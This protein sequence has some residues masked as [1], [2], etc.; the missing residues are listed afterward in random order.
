MVVHARQPSLEHLSPQRRSTTAAAL[1]R[2]HIKISE[3]VPLENSGPSPVWKPGSIH[4]QS[5][6]PAGQHENHPLPTDSVTGFQGSL[7]TPTSMAMAG[8]D[9][10]A[11]T[12]DFATN[13]PLHESSLPMSPDSNA[14]NTSSGG[15]QSA[16]IVA[17][18]GNAMH[19]NR[20]SVFMRDTKDGVA[21]LPE[22]DSAGFPS[23]TRPSTS[24]DSWDL[25]MDTPN[26]KKRRS[27]SIR[28]AFRRMFSKK[29]KQAP[30]RESP[31]RANGPRHEYHS[32]EP[33]LFPSSRGLDRVTEEDRMTPQK[34]F[35]GR[36]AD[37]DEY[38]NRTPIQTPRL[39]FPMNING[40]QPVPYTENTP[41]IE[42]D[43]SRTYTSFDTSPQAHRRRA[44][45]PSIVIS[46]S[47]AAAL[48]K[49]WNKADHVSGTPPDSADPDRTPTPLIGL[50]ITSNAP[51]KASSKS[52]RR[53]SR[54]ADALRDLAQT[55]QGTTDLRRRSA[56]IQYWRN[57]E[58]RLPE[59]EEAVEDNGPRSQHASV[60]EMGETPSSH[61][62]PEEQQQTSYMAAAAEPIQEEDEPRSARHVPT[63]PAPQS[64]PEPVKV[65]QEEA[66][67]D[68]EPAPMD[69]RISQL[70]FSMTHLER[71]M[72]AL[73]GR[74]HQAFKLEKAPRSRGRMSTDPDHHRQTLSVGQPT[75]ASSVRTATSPKIHHPR[76]SPSLHDIS[77]TTHL[78]A[79]NNS[80]I[81]RSSML[82]ASHTSANPTPTNPTFNAI[83]L[84]PT[85]T[86][87]FNP[88]SLNH[89][90]REATPPT[91]P[92]F[93]IPYAP[94]SS[95]T[96]LIDTLA[97]LYS[98]LQYERAVR[99]TLESTV[100]QLQRDLLSLTNIV[101]EMRGLGG[102][103]TP[104]PDD[105]LLTKAQ[106]RD[107]PPDLVG[108]SGED[109]GYE[110]DGDG[111]EGDEYGTYDEEGLG[112]PNAWVTPRE[113]RDGFSAEMF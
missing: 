77:Q 25:S 30:V 87:T 34:Q 38:R 100:H 4:R 83:P 12:S 113:G 98:A 28:G 106:G 53:R 65:V 50:A 71:S 61:G 111:Y 107:T 103:P 101:A 82:P 52:S 58:Q 15:Q 60:M 16:E 35:R 89:T 7:A 81:H 48:E 24:R 33:A 112:S 14:Y 74:Q 5:Q 43:F 79:T 47:D 40:A 68:S 37:E 17:G 6:Y 49:F 110:G 57:T 109:D 88:S 13:G 72:Q 56:E 11:S 45:L 10:H 66:A 32:S 97:P 104:S 85:T 93:S 2:G 20:S 96:H 91:I 39:P 41:Y 64:S 59:V 102:Y 69:K 105:V 55:Q 22:P 29:E 51:S 99:K 23:Q 31:P 90:S 46:A 18:D 92:N 62:H 19:L 44:T 67:D 76:P 36:T 8:S 9:A 80:H 78:N 26:K 108:D 95:P 1:R 27:G 70:E 73:S 42:N 94:S 75:R 86:T 3:P 63:P 21:R 54:S 84:S